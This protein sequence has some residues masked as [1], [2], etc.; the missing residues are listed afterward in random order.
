MNVLA[1]AQPKKE[2]EKAE[3]IL[4]NMQAST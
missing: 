4:M 1:L 2:K 3:Q